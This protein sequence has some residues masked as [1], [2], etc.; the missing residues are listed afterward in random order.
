MLV[1][2]G[3]QIATENPTYICEGTVRM[4]QDGGERIN[5]I[6]CHA[7]FQPKA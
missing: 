6:G 3:H 2:T 1:N 7:T 5:N 4:L